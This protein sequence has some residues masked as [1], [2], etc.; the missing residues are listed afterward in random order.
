MFDFLTKIYPKKRLLPWKFIKNAPKGT[1]QT[2][3]ISAPKKKKKVAEKVEA[4]AS[5]G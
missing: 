5:E 3:K 1:W 2:K 4:E